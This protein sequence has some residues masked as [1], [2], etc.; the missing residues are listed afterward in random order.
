MPVPAAAGLSTTGGPI[1][2]LTTAGDLQVS[3]SVTTSGAHDV[4]LETQAPGAGADVLVN[5][6]VSSMGGN[7]SIVSTD[8]IIQGGSGDISS[9]GGEPLMSKTGHS[10]IKARMQETGALLAGEMSGHIFFKERWYGFDDAIYSAARLLEILVNSGS[11]AADV[12]AE[13][14][15]GVATPELRIDLPEER[16]QPFMEQVIAAA[17]FDDGEISQID[18]LRVDFN[19]SWGLVR[20]SNT[21]PCL[22]LRFEGD[23]EA[24]LEGVKTRFRDLIAGL[25][26]SLDI[27]F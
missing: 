16:H 27:P 11:S 8:D 15:G 25:D 23:D 26:S 1:K 2:V 6:V 5:D 22:V 10:L 7:I 14:P 12:F 18:G 17:N 21:T 20:P 9:N 19:D 13:L 3:A 24:A 4:L